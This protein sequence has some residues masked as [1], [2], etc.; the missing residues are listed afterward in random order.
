M[1]LWGR[2][3]LARSDRPGRP[4]ATGPPP[5]VGRAIP[6]A[7]VHVG[8]W[9]LTMTT[10]PRPWVRC[11]AVTRPPDRDRTGRILS[12]RIGKPTD[13]LRHNLSEI[14]EVSLERTLRI[15]RIARPL[16]SPD[17]SFGAGPDQRSRR[18]PGPSPERDATG[19]ILP[20]NRLSSLRLRAGA[21]G[22]P[23]E[24]RGPPFCGPT[25]GG[26]P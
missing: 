3:R 12:R 16:P 9:K 6:F 13:R 22:S 7:P 11:P 24:P 5:V 4:I 21:P 18:S 14:E 19:R 15:V 23:L 10:P 17:R 26:G 2:G 8:S 20:E 1:S 25:S